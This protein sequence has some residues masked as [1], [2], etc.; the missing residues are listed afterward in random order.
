MSRRRLIGILILLALVASARPGAH[1]GH[2][3][4]IMGAVVSRDDKAVGVK[5]PSGEV[6]SIAI[7]HETV[8]LRGK[9]KADIAEVNKGVRVVVDIGDGE[10]PLVAREIRLGPVAASRK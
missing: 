7:T 9:K 4:T 6:L 5:T 2:S 10:D 8:V 1:P 3:H